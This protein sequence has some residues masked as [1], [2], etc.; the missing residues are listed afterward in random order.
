V[1]SHDLDILLRSWAEDEAKRELSACRLIRET[2]DAKRFVANTQ[3]QLAFWHISSG[4]LIGV[5]V[6]GNL[7]RP[8]AMKV[9]QS[10]VC[11]LHETTGHQ[12]S[13]N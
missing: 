5:E 7:A 9:D 10:T 8:L 12:W 2:A 6:D 4:C 13:P 1:C 11:K 3:T